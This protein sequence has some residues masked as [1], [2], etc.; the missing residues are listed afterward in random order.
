MPNT[1]SST[2]RHSP[3]EIQNQILVYAGRF[4]DEIH[5]D[6]LK[7]LSDRNTLPYRLFPALA[8]AEELI[9]LD[10][11]SFPFEIL[12]TEHWDIPM[13]VFI[14]PD[15]TD[16]VVDEILGQ[17]V[18]SQLTFLDRF[19]CERDE[20]W[21]S[22][23]AKYGWA[24]SQRF[25]IS[26]NNTEGRLSAL[27]PRLVDDE[28]EPLQPPEEGYVYSNYWEQRALYYSSPISDKL[29][30]SVHHSRRANKSM[31]RQQLDAF[32]TYL[33][34]ITRPVSMKS[35]FSLLEVGCGVGRWCSILDP[36][37][38]NYH[39]LDV[40]PTMVQNAKKNYP[41]YI[42][43]L[44]DASLNFPYPEERFDIVFTVTVLHHVDVSVKRV[45]LKEMFRVLRPG[46][47][48][49]CLEDFVYG[50]SHPSNTVYPMGIQPFLHLLLDTTHSQLSL[51][52]VKTLRYQHVPT[53][54]T[55]LLSF[56][57]IA[58]TRKW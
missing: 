20:L 19:Y 51:H 26:S 1:L 43:T 16:A 25:Q 36:A 54:Q 11:P 30:C 58:P 23:K 15:Y 10:V 35:S 50:K 33:R 56:V 40:A 5:T 44:L 39:G 13:T 24:D 49:I 48:L 42:F 18:F 27:V 8:E 52:H 31:H 55:A 41:S 22:L 38:H 7:I 32:G 34:A 21:R 29:F 6:S 14:P 45:L 53:L 12:E 9:L 4:R 17:P 46:G 57:K 28:R 37:Q 2:P 47:F 3:P